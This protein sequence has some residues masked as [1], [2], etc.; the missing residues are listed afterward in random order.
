[1]SVFVL[2][3]LSFVPLVFFLVLFCLAVP[4]FKVRY[5]LG[6]TLVGL[7]S[8]IPIVV[9][10]YFVLKLPDFTDHSLVEALVTVMVFNGLVEETVKMLSLLLLPHKKMGIGVFL[11][12][13]LISG[14]A[15]GCFETVIYLF[16]GYQ[17][18]QIRSLTAVAMHSLCGGLSGI[19][20]WTWR[21]PVEKAPGK[22]VPLVMPFVL[23]VVLH[24]V[25]NFFAGFSGGF[26]WFSVVAILMAALECRIWY[27]KAA[28][29][30]GEAS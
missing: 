27:R 18:I 6:S 30:D 3:G 9:V 2:M 24:G 4:G 22:K 20:V 13:S 1:M 8:L 29:M 19:Y 26:W 12:M 21:N 16:S 5:G 10:Q 25:Y 28:G 15:L 14:L 11:A 23:A 7:F 17:N